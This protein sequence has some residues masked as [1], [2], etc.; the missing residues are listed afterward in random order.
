MF[1]LLRHEKI[2]IYSKLMNNPFNKTLFNLEKN[3]FE[4][5]SVF[6]DLYED[7]EKR[8]GVYLSPDDV[9]MVWDICRSSTFHITLSGW[10]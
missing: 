7:I 2:V 9:H 1:L 8:T 5:S 4:D 6:V 10:R 3:K